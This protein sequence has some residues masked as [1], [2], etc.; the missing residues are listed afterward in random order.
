LIVGQ[1]EKGCV[2]LNALASESVIHER[3]C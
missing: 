1:M 2:V 3:G